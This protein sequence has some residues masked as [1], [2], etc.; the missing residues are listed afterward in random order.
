MKHGTLVQRRR[1]SYRRKEIKT[2]GW[3]W[4]PWEDRM[5][6]G[7]K[8]NYEYIPDGWYWYGPVFRYRYDPVPGVKHWRNSILSYYRRM[9]T[10]QERRWSLAHQPYVRGKR[11]K[12]NLPNSWDDYHYARREKG[13][14]RTKKKRQWMK[15]GDKL[16][17]K[18]KLHEEISQCNEADWRLQETEGRL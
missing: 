11:N 15:K 8:Y 10:T 4:D 12:R 6:W 14:K 17:E 7:T 1:R 16:Y 18:R 9:K 5:Y 3:R 2:V 13:W